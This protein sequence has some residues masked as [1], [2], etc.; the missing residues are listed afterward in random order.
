MEALQSLRPPMTSRLRH[1]VRHSREQPEQDSQTKNRAGSLH[2]SGHF[3]EITKASLAA[4]GRGPTPRPKEENDEFIQSWLQQ[5]QARHSH[6]SRPD[7][8]RRQLRLTEQSSARDH[9]GKHRKR[10]RPILESSPPSPEAAERV[11]N[12]FE[13][14][15]RHKTRD[16]KYDYKPHADKKRAS[17]QGLRSCTTTDARKDRALAV[18]GKRSAR[19]GDAQAAASHMLPRTSKLIPKANRISRHRNL[20][21][22]NS[23][24]NASKLKL[25]KSQKEDKELE[26]FSA[27]FSRRM[28]HDKPESRS[29]GVA[30]RAAAITATVRRT[31]RNDVTEALA[32]TKAK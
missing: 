9:V 11:E 22:K 10:P 24:P 2:T 6:L 5:M 19:Q 32:S 30:D 31:V 17:G 1:S 28:P 16:D 14:R 4:L 3:D 7:H 20:T 21:R 15:T 18:E 27:F 8:E 26:E 23:E 25:S 12:R 13:K 29:Y